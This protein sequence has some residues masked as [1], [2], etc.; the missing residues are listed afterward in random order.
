MDDFHSSIFCTH[1]VLEHL[2]GEL[3][4]SNVLKDEKYSSVNILKDEFHTS[5]PTV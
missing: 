1:R 5:V 2:N 3:H 4:P